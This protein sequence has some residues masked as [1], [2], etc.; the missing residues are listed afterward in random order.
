MYV[1]TSNVPSTRGSTDRDCAFALNHASLAPFIRV[2]TYAML[3][4]PS[5]FWDSIIWNSKVLSSAT[6]LDKGNG[7]GNGKGKGKGKE[8][9]IDEDSLT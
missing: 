9:L 6:G 1:K 3:Q 5:A 2:D 8:G 4:D 7:K